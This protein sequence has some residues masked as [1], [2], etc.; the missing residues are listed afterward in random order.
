MRTPSSTAMT[1][2][3]RT[4]APSALI[5]AL[6]AALLGLC[7]GAC[8]FAVPAGAAAATVSSN[9]AGY[10]ALP[11]GAGRSFQSVSG[12]WTQPSVTCSKGAESFSAVWVGLGGYREDS[13]ALEQ[14]GT[15]ADCSRSG[16]ASYTTWSE[17][18]PAAP[19]TLK[20]ATS[21][22]DQITAS[23]TVHG[24]DVTMR[25]RNLTTDARYSVTRRLSAIDTSSADWI[26]EAPSTCY[27]ERNCNALPLSDFGI[28]SFSGATAT[29]GS[30]T[31]PVASP[32][33]PDVALELRQGASSFGPG[34][35]RNTRAQPAAGVIAATP[36]APSST[37][38]A[39]SVA[40][41]EQ[42]L[43]GEEPPVRPFPGYRSGLEAHSST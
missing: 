8:A 21:P 11:A 27:T 33:W 2:S 29:V 41:T 30:R 3:A 37:L 1:R 40:F 13:N 4:P 25:L 17:L 10:V 23:V 35:A 24:H 12:S 6:C 19:V 32:G 36:S 42:Q 7:A 34:S 5:R 31:A 28:V 26:V 9:W 39:F 43:R 18:I 20:I 16:E 38:G 14:I 15:E 22:G